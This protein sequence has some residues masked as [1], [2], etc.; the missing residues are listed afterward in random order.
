MVAGFPSVSVVGDSALAITLDGRVFRLAIETGEITGKGRTPILGAYTV[1]RDAVSFATPFVLSE[2]SLRDFAEMERIEYRREVEPL[3][4]GAGPSVNGV[5]VTSEAA[6]WTTMDGALMAVSRTDAPGRRRVWRE[7]L[8][9]AIVA[10][11]DAPVAGA[12]HFYYT[13]KSPDSMELLCFGGLA[14]S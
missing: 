2:F 12:E 3:Y 11:S 6:I 7:E 1:G 9:R 5:C 4:R 8:A 14:G 13:K 10:I